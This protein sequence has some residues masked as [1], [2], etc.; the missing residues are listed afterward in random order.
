MRT[1]SALAA[2]L[3][4]AACK[5]ALLP[6]TEIEETPETRAVYDVV[7]AYRLGM[8][9]RDPDRVLALVSKDYFETG[10]TEDPADDYGYKELDQ[11]LR[12]DFER[13]IALRLDLYLNEIEVDESEAAVTYR[14]RSRAQVRLPA[15][16]QWVTHTDVNQMR[17]RKKDDAW[18]II[19]GL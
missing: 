13:S 3:I 9:S 19:S 15:G 6:H 10:G 14:Y 12:A 8:E 7:E 16:D 4:L 2:L 11:H 18:Q 1:F 5:P 17:L